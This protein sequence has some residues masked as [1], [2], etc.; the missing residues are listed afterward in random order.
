MR[1]CARVSFLLLCPKEQIKITNYRIEE[2]SIKIEREKKNIIQ[3]RKLIWQNFQNQ[4]KKE[5]KK[6][7]PKAIYEFNL[8]EQ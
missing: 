2:H 7:G 3:Q 1:K 4:R 8:N 6:I 5:K